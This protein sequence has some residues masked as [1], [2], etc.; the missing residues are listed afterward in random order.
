MAGGFGSVRRAA[1]TP[2]NMVLEARAARIAAMRAIPPY[3]RRCPSIR[4]SGVPKWPVRLRRKF[5]QRMADLTRF[6]AKSRCV[7]SAIDFDAAPE[8]SK[9]VRTCARLGLKLTRPFTDALVLQLNR[10]EKR[11]YLGRRPQVMD[12]LETAAT[13][14]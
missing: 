8:N 6:A 10:L 13:A 2:F 14:T 5:L 3:V 4:T 1:E 12:S 7:V 11:P 9:L